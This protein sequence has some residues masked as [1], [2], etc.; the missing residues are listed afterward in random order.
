MADLGSLLASDPHDERLRANVRPPDWRNPTPAAWYDLVVIGGGTAGLVSA[1]LAGLLGARVALVER[2]LA[3]G[4]CLVTG[5]VPSKAVIRAGRAAHDT[6]AAAA[7][8]VR[9]PPPEQVDVDF[10]AA[11]D[12]MRRVR[13][14]ISRHDAVAE[15]S[16]TYKVDVFLGAARFASPDSVDVDGTPLRFGRAVVATGA[17]PAVPPIPGLTDIAFL[18]SETVFNL[19]SRP[20]RLGVLGGGP[21]GCELAQAFARLGSRVTL[22]DHGDQLLGREDPDAADLLQR[23]LSDEG[24]E[25]SLGTTVDRTERTGAATSLLCR[26]TGGCERRIEVDALLVATGRRANVEGLRLEAAGV[27]YDERGVTVDDRLRTTN[28]RVFAAGDVCLPGQRFTHAADASARVAVQN[29]LVLPLKRWSRQIVPWVT[30]TDPEVARVGLSETDARSHGVKVGVHRVPLADV[31]RAQTDGETD[32][33]VK[34]LT[35]GRGDRIA[36][37]TIVGRHAG[38]MISQV[39][40]AMGSGVGLRALSGVVF[41]YPTQAEAIRKAADAYVS[42]TVGPKLRWALGRWLALRR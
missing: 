8:G 29:A 23:V 3:G 10:A 14:E 19:T 24:I 30:Y 22:I 42:A 36:G 7:F 12:R 32:G 26:I 15:F 6:R 9:V 21:I 2:A 31:D 41:P 27:A 11:M 13:A 16:R 38:E 33:F 1:G 35:R 4:D 40:A 20:A 34:V 5:C 39:T 37:A 25:L 18:T 17:R 28:R